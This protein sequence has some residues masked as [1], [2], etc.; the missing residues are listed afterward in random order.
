M[1]METTRYP[2][3]SNTKK[4]AVRRQVPQRAPALAQTQC[5]RKRPELLRIRFGPADCIGV[6]HAPLVARGADRK[7]LPGKCLEAETNGAKGDSL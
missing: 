5:S 1:T 7:I 4:S 3:H 2:I 6:E